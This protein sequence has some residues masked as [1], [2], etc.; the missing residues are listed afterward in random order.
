MGGSALTVPVR[1]FDKVEFFKIWRELERK[2]CFELM[3]P[4]YS[5]LEKEDFGDM[6]IICSKPTVSDYRQY[7]I[8]NL[9]PLCIVKNSNVTSFEYKGIQVDLIV[10]PPDQF[11]WSHYYYSNNDLGNLLG[12]VARNAGFKFGG[13][14]FIYEFSENQ[15]NFHKE[16]LIT[17]DPE[18]ALQYL[19]YSIA[20]S[21]NTYTDMFEYV[22]SSPIADPSQFY[23]ENRNFEG[24]HRDKKR[25]VYLMFLEWLKAEYGA[26]TNS[27][28]PLNKL[29][30]LRRAFKTYP[31]FEKG[32]KQAQANYVRLL[33]QREQ[34]NGELVADLTGLEG[35]RL[36]EFIKYF[37]SLPEF[38]IVQQTPE[39]TIHMLI[40]DKYKLWNKDTE[41]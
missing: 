36:G 39:K 28:Y 34:F 3:A 9:H 29:A 6:D 2:L 20:N 19:G 14:G 1:R 15:G 11:N 25:K 17:S 40:G 10:V 13:Q 16:I 18:K 31:R 8:D 23:F 37:R 4:T 32:Y 38:A 21:F 30:H 24:R 26:V 7:I 27:K 5:V 12:R 41:L 33:H 35:K 22:M